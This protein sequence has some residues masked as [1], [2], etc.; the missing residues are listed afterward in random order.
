VGEPMTRL[1][2]IGRRRL[3]L[4]RREFVAGT[5]ALAAG[6]LV[7]VS[8]TAFQ[9]APSA[10]LSRPIDL[11]H[12]FGPPQWRAFLSSR[13]L[14]HPSWNGWTPER[15]LDELDRA[16]V[17]AAMI[18]ITYPG[19]W[20]GAG[21]VPIEE[22]RTLARQSNDFGA[23]MVA[24]HPSRFG[25][26]AVLP[27]PDVEGSLREVA[28]AFDTLKVDGVGILTSY[29][30]KW[31]GD[32]AFA[33]L[34]EELNR[35]K[36]VV[37]THANVPSCCTRG[38]SGA[39]RYLVPGV[40]NNVVEYGTDTTRAIMSLVVMNASQRYPNIRFTFS[41]GGGT[42]PYLIERI[43][44]RK[45]MASLTDPSRP[46]ARL[47][48]L[49]QFYYDTANANNVVAMSALKKV[50]GVSQIALG[51]DFPYEGPVAEQLSDLKTCGAF[52]DEELRTICSE[53]ARKLA[54]RFN[55]V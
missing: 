31:L 48:Q 18:S 54:P 22:T 13:N 36:A 14:L 21:V 25:L 17:A 39:D 20:L 2:S 9:T 32:T 15:S 50:V 28:Y 12:H 8:A 47:Q 11:H 53:N 44:G 19:I 27:L 10:N 7:P 42:M 37:F 35:R 29:G 43:L 34:F 45:E 49:R 46:N 33:P 40:N 3:L 5:A 16:A 55:K 24:D 51:T 38:G 26:F 1:H 4:S 23:R 52:N 6:M 41:H 30:D